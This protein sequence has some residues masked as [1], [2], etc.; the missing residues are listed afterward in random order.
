MGTGG[1]KNWSSVSLPHVLYAVSILYNTTADSVKNLLGVDEVDGNCLS[2]LKVAVQNRE[3]AKAALRSKSEHP[4][5]V[6][7]V[8][9]GPLKPK[10]PV[11][12][13]ARPK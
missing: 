1:V 8:N 13:T 6:S 3:V 5:Q 9:V 11:A 2:G 10:R 4:C 7:G 12:M